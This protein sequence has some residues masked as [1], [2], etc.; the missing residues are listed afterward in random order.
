MNVE[1][2]NSSGHHISDIRV[3]DVT[4]QPDVISVYMPPDRHNTIDALY[5]GTHTTACWNDHQTSGSLFMTISLN[6]RPTKFSIR[7]YRP[8]YAPGWIIKENGVIILAETENRGSAAQPN[9][10]SY[11]Y[12]LPPF[13]SVDKIFDVTDVN[14]VTKN[15]INISSSIQLLSLIHI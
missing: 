15:G 11:D 2:F 12:I 10:I 13:T 9:P 14:T 4:I 5:D 8:L 7:Y 1:H 6:Y 3:N